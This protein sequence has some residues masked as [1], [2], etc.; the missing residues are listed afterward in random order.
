MDAEVH[1]PPRVLRAQRLVLLPAQ[2]EL[3]GQ[4]VEIGQPARPQPGVAAHV[5]HHLVQGQGLVAALDVA[6]TGTTAFERATV[7]PVV[8]WETMSSPGRVVGAAVALLALAGCSAYRQLVGEDTVSL[9]QAE[10][11]RMEVELRRPV[12]TMATP[13]S[14][15]AAITSASRTDPPG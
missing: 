6:H 13:C 5:V 9:E 3:A 11:L 4:P 1:E 7:K 2:A 12:K 15:A 10:V 8:S 14:S